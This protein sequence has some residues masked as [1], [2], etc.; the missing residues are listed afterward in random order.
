MDN[1]V[2]TEV[3]LRSTSFTYA[4]RAFWCDFKNADMTGVCLD[5]VDLDPERL[6][7]T[8]GLYMPLCC[9]EEGSF[10]AWKKCREGKI[11]K[12][13]I[14]EHAERKGNIVSSCRASEAMVLEIY[15]KDGDPIDEATSQYNKDFKY[16]KGNQFLVFS[17]VRAYINWLTESILDFRIK[18]K[19]KGEGTYEN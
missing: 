3:N 4:K 15:D 19:M 17:I 1:A 10:I 11:V 16:A 18:A 8:K 5:E 7:G 13:L 6:K 2:F 12:L 9:P 14:P